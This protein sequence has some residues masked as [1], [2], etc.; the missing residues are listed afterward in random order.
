[1]Q[2]LRI[3]I[4]CY[5][6]YGGSGVIASEI[7]MGM[8]RRGH[9]VHFIASGMPRRLDR[10]MSNIYFHEVEM[11]DYPVF[12]SP[13]YAIGL[14][15]KIVDVSTYEKLDILHVHY[16]VPHATSAYLAK[17]V[18]GASSPKIITTLHGT[19]ITLVGNDRSYLPITRFSI[20]Q[21]DG[22]T[23]PSQY[24]K[25]A[26]YDKLN[27]STD[28]PVEVI[29][30]FVDTE[31]YQPGND[32][33]K[34]KLSPCFKDSACDGPVLTHVSNFRA[35]KRIPDI[36]EVF[37]RVN[38]EVPSKLILIG[39]GPERGNAERLVFEKK[40]T[41]KVC[42]LGKLETF[43]EILQGTTVFLLPSESESF[44]LAA[45]EAQSCGIPVVASNAGGIP[46]VVIDGETGFL[47]DIGDVQDMAKNVLKII[48]DSALAKK[49][50]ENA[51]K[52][53]LDNFSYDKLIEE[54]EKYYLYTLSK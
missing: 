11:R 37:A 54:Y 10:Y 18:L 6:T 21:S 39:D 12:V 23:T 3:G 32:G 29:G 2:Q 16:A 20:V 7:G 38:A 28:F 14:A 44:G 13:P 19:D 36:I 42:F 51:R 30:N 47:S 34:T 4:V 17:Q 33:I 1:M 48:N 53:V 15:S 24:L 46:E 49:L 8:A 5:P 43:T 9:R 50:G 31:E 52:R 41:D 26:T 22:V 25:G 45:L 40:L 35:V 27:V